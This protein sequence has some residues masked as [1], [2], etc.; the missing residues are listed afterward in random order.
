MKTTTTAYP[1]LP[2]LAPRA[3]DESTQAYGLRALAFVLQTGVT[4]TLN[5]ETLACADHVYPIAIG[6]PDISL[7]AAVRLADVQREVRAALR[8]RASVPIAAEAPA[9]TGAPERP[10][11]GP[12]APLAPPPVRPV[13]PATARPAVATPGPAPA[14]RE[15]FAF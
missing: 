9:T 15:A 1:R 2:E 13:P 8:R 14:P 4:A 11:A 3:A 10:T 7:T 5:E 12:M 6:H